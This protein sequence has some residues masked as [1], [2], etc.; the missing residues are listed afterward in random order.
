VAIERS[1]IVVALLA[2]P[3]KESQS[4]P[5]LLIK[6]KKEKREKVLGGLEG[7]E[8]VGEGEGGGNTMRPSLFTTIA[9]G[10]KWGTAPLRFIG[11]GR[12]GRGLLSFC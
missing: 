12:E 4:D 10:R 6:R 7:E 9:G 5:N 1:L 11:P 8:P 3:Q 2:V